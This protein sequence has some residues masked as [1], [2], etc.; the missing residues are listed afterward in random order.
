MTIKL[1]VDVLQDKIVKYSIMLQWTLGLKLYST[2]VLPWLQNTD[3][4]VATEHNLL[5]CSEHNV[6]EVVFCRCD[7][8]INTINFT[9]CVPVH[10]MLTGGQTETNV[11]F[12]Y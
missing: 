9:L 3:R 7:V 8:H 1:N 10:F 12:C 6:S 2:K 4:N 5:T 11:S